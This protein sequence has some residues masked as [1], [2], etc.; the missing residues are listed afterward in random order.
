MHLL[1]SV[2]VE[3]HVKNRL[4]GV[5]VIANLLAAAAFWMPG[6]LD[7]DDGGHFCQ[8]GAEACR[9]ITDSPWLPDGCYIEEGGP[10]FS[11]HQNWECY[12]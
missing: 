8:A 10:E 12:S 4:F 3:K 9:C 7:A 5:L 6:S 2:Q 1:D 11:C